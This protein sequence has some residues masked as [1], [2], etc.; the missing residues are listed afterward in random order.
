MYFIIIIISVFMLNNI[1]PLTVVACSTTD[2]N[3]VD[4]DL[5]DLDCQQLPFGD[6]EVTIEPLNV[7][8]ILDFI[9]FIYFLALDTPHVMSTYILSS[10]H[11]SLFPPK[12]RN[13]KSEWI[14]G[15]SGHGNPLCLNVRQ[16]DLLCRE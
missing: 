11:F 3:F 9:L 4:A 8:L 5:L 10:T 13:F 2:C 12:V 1:K 7:E 6:N 16:M 14:L 15:H